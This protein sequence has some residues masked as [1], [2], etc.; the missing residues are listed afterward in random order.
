MKRTLGWKIVDVLLL[1]LN[2]YFWYSDMSTMSAFVVG[3]VAGSIVYSWYLVPNLYTQIKARDELI[4]KLLQDKVKLTAS[5]VEE[6]LKEHGVIGNVD[7]TT[8]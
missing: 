3:L 6:V 4:E 2:S 8:H 1:G 7:N 5:K